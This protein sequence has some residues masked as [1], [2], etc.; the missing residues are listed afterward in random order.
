MKQNVAS[1]PRRVVRSVSIKKEKFHAKQSLCLD[2]R[3]RRRDICKFTGYLYCTV[4]QYIIQ[5]FIYL[6][7]HIHA[8]NVLAKK[9]V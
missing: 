2:G 4:D 3:E 9:F 6:V 8:K 7:L 1:L 5:V